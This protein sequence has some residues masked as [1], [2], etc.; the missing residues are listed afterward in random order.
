MLFIAQVWHRGLFYC[1]TRL[2]SS[3][4]VHVQG[5][6]VSSGTGL[7]SS[8]QAGIDANTP[9]I[10]NPVSIIHCIKFIEEL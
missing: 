5:A 9:R 7:P 4:A 3:A 1:A 8:T 6:N 10:I 2:S